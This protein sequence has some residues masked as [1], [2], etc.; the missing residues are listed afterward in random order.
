MPTNLTPLLDP[1]DVQILFADLQPSIVARS[2]TNPPDAIARSAGVMAGV[3]ALLGLPLHFSVVPEGGDDPVLIPELA[4]HGAASQLRPRG[5]A[6]PFLEEATRTALSATGRKTLVLCGFATEV[7]VLHAVRGAIEAGYSVLVPVDACGSMSARTEDATFRQIEAAGGATTSVVG[8][9]TA[10]AADF[11]RD[12][13]SKH[14]RCCKRR[15]SDNLPW[16]IN[17]VP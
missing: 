10:M 11:S 12:R 5:S 2:R 1:A 15:V 9:A 6:S 7:V 8:I 14:S 3:G 17:A 13:D 16:D 4:R